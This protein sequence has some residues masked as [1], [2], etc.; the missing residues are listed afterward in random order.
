MTTPGG[1]PLSHDEQRERER[2]WSAQQ[3]ERE[4]AWTE[5]HRKRQAALEVEQRE[6]ERVEFA[7]RERTAWALGKRGGRIG[8]L[9]VTAPDGEQVRIAVVWL[10]RFRATRKPL[11]DYAPLRH[12][13]PDG[14][15]V[16][17]LIPIAALIGLDFAL[18]W[19]VLALLG[20]PRWAVGAAVGD[21]RG[22]GGDNN[23]VL[24]RTR[25]RDTALRQASALADAVERTGRTALTPLTPLTPR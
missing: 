9:D 11:D 20:R 15:G 12:V 23:L 16:L 17:L 14:E 10:G 21:D 18:R 19:A 25:H 13:I 2:A 6:Q 1:R 24:L 4:R 22:K 8:H 5:E 3:K 7:A